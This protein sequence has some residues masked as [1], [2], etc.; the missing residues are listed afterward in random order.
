MLSFHVGVRVSFMTDRYTY[1]ES[2]G[3]AVVEVVLMEDTSL[4]VVVSAWEVCFDPLTNSCLACPFS[5]SNRSIFSTE[6]WPRQSGVQWYGDVYCWWSRR[7]DCF[8]NNYR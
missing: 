7:T 5:L 2:D 8:S 1:Q 4:D 3:Q 6:H